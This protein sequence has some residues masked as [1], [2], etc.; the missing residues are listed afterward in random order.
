MKVGE[1]AEGKRDAV[2][3][4]TANAL[5]TAIARRLAD[6]AEEDMRARYD[7]G[8]ALALVEDDRTELQN[9]VANAL[10]VHRSLLRRYARVATVIR[11]DEL[12]GLVR[13]R[14]RVGM[15]L[16]WSHIEHLAEITSAKIRESMAKRVIAEGLSV[17]A[18]RSRL[19]QGW[20]SHGPR[21]RG[22]DPGSSER[23]GPGPVVH[24][25]AALLQ[26]PN[27]RIA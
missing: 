20:R 27:D 23:S 26:T 12:D 25:L 21:T 7:L 8:R 14:D 16:S 24:S 9:D 15:P 11:P 2:R 22:C 3:A 6:A 4:R 5:A 13:L 1:T 19:Q 10:G 17:R 18:L